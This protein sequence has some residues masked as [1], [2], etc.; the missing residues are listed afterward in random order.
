VTGQ[1]HVGFCVFLACMILFKP[2]GLDSRNVI[3]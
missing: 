3:R 2:V 1:G